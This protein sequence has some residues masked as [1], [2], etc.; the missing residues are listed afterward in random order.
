MSS[1]S[2]EIVDAC[3]GRVRTPRGFERLSKGSLR[4]SNGPGTQPRP[5]ALPKAARSPKVDARML[6]RTDWTALK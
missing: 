3:T 5:T 6:P 1:R 4:L 2:V